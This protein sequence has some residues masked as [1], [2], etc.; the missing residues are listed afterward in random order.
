MSIQTV[1][2]E[3]LRHLIY[4]CEYAAVKYTAPTCETCNKLAPAFEALSGKREYNSILFLRI[5]ADEN[6]TAKQFLAERA[7]PLM[8]VYH[9]GMVVKADTA[10]TIDD[11]TAMLDELLATKHKS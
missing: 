9:N 5:D 7:T 11:I 4:S 3:Q 10:Y 1:D 2:D 8:V 6:P